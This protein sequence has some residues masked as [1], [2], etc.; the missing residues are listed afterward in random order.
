MSSRQQSQTVFNSLRIASSDDA[1]NITAVINSAFR[2]AEE[3]F[4]DGDRITVAEVRKLLLSGEFLL[5]EKAGRIA[6]CV[7]VEPRGDRAYLGLLSVDPEQQQS[8]LGSLLV[9]AAEERCFE[10]G[11]RFM[12]INVVNLR[13]ELFGFYLR[14]GYV[15]CGS[16]PFPKNV[17]T[18]LPCHFV[19]MSKALAFTETRHTRSPR[20]L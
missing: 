19:K 15:E 14:R 16:E 17:E 5:A 11:C 18:R 1:E 13:E 9:K 20:S 2:P 10:R 6:A 12:D 4:V 7:Y 8:G 3:F